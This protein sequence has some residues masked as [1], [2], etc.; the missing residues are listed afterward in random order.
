MSTIRVALI[1]RLNLAEWGLGGAEA[2]RL[3]AHV[4]AM[5]MYS[6][7]LQILVTAE[8]RRTLESEAR[9]R[10][11]SV[12]ALVREAIDARFDPIG[13]DR[14]RAAFEELGRIGERN[15]GIDLAVEELEA[16][17]NDSHTDEIMRGVA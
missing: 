1:G 16:L 5:H 2:P 12:G 15:R 10:G 4:Y 17:V 6:E 9:R 11:A 7:R 8:Q 3:G 14:R 13:S